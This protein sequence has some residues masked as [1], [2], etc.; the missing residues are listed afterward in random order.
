M[1][2]IQ[3][4][5]WAL[6]ETKRH[7]AEMEK[8]GYA[9]AKIKEKQASAA[10]QQANVA[11]RNVAIAESLEPYEKWQKATGSAKNIGDTWKSTIGQMISDKTRQGTDILKILFG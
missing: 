11:E 10:Q 5:Y 1:T 9:E 8:L 7:N 4:Q 6:Q 3:N 2:S